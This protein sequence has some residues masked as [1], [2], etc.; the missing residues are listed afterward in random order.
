MLYPRS[1]TARSSP[2]VNPLDVADV[3]HDRRHALHVAPHHGVRHPCGCRELLD[4]VVGAL[5]GLAERQGVVEENRRRGS[6]HFD[7]S[8]RRYRQQGLTHGV[9]LQQ[10]AAD[11]A[12]VRVADLDKGLAGGA[13]RR[14]SEIEAPVGVASSQERNVK[15]APV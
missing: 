1:I 12:R 8:R 14:V 6:R 13:M 10:I 9:L 7:Q 11:Q 15:H 3:G 5:A 2:R 4:V